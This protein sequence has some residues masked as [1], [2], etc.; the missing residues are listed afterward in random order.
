MFGVQLI[1]LNVVCFNIHSSFLACPALENFLATPYGEVNS[2]NHCD[3]GVSVTR[4]CSN[5]GVWG[6]ISYSGLCRCTQEPGWQDGLVGDVLTREC[7][8]GRVEVSCNEVGHWMTIQNDCACAADGIWEQSAIGVTLEKVCGNGGRMRRTCGANGFWEDIQDFNCECPKDGIWD[9]TPAGEF[10]RAGCS[11]GFIY[12]LCGENGEWTETYD[13]SSCY[14]SPQSGWQ[15]TLNGATATKACPYGEQV[16]ECDEWGRWGEIDSSNCMCKP[17]DGFEATPVNSYATTSCFDMNGVPD[18][19]HTQTRYCD[20]NGNWGDIDQTQCPI[21]WC[22]TVESWY[23]VPVGTRP[24]RVSIGCMSGE[25]WRVCNVNGQ[26]GPVNTDNCDC[27]YSLEDEIT[28]LL[29]PGDSYSLSCAIGERVYKCNEESGYFDPVDLS[30]CKC[31]S[32]GRFVSTPAGELASAACSVGTSVRL[33]SYDGQWEEADNSRCFCGGSDVWR[34]TNFNTTVS[35]LCDSG[36]RMRVCNEDGFWD[37]A[38]QD[39]CK[40]VSEGME[41]ALGSSAVIS[42][43]EGSIVYACNDGTFAAPDTSSCYCSSRSEFGI[44]WNRI[45]AGSDSPL[46]ICMNGFSQTRHCSDLTGHWEDLNSDE[47]HCTADGIW[48]ETGVGEYAYAPCEGHSTG[49]RRRMCYG[50]HWGDIDESTCYSEC[51]FDAGNGEITYVPVDSTLEVPCYVN[52]NGA[53]TY[54]CMHNEETNESY[55]QLIGSTCTRLFCESDLPPYIIHAG[56]SEERSCINGFTGTRTHTCQTDGTWSDYDNSNCSPIVCPATTYSGL[57]FPVTLADTYG[58]IECENGYHGTRKLFC[59]I[60]GEWTTDYLDECSINICPQEGEW[61]ETEAFKS[62]TISCP[63]DYTGSWTRQCLA[64]GEWEELAIPETCIPTP[65]TMKSIPYEGM[66]HVSRAPSVS[67]FTSLAIQEP[68]DGCDMKIVSV[69]NPEEEYTLRTNITKTALQG[70]YNNGGIFADFPLPPDADIHDLSHYLKYGEY[71]AIIPACWKALNGAAVPETQYEVTFHTTAIPPSSPT[72]ITIQYAATTFSVSFEEP[73]YVDEPYPVIAYYLS[74]QPPVYPE[75]RIDATKHTF[76]PFNYIAGSVS[77]LLRAENA[78]GLSS[79]DVEVP[80]NFDDVLIDA[81]ELL[82]MEIPSPEVVHLYSIPQ[83]SSVAITVGIRIPIAMQEFASYLNVFCNGEQVPGYEDIYQTKYTFIAS[84]DDV[85]T[86]SCYFTLAGSSSELTVL[87][88]PVVYSTTAYAAPEVTAIES[89]AHFIHLSWNEPAKYTNTPI[90]S[91]IVECKQQDA[92]TYSISY[93]ITALEADISVSSITVGPVVC[94]VGASS[95]YE[96][97][98]QTA[99]GMATIEELHTV[100]ANDLSLEVKQHGSYCEVMLMTSY[101]IE[102]IATINN[103]NYP[104]DSEV[105]LTCN[106]EHNQMTGILSMLDLS[107]TYSLTVSVPS[108]P[109][110][111][112]SEITTL[113]T[114]ENTFNITINEDLLYGTAAVAHIVSDSKTQVYCTAYTTPIDMDVF[115]YEYVQSVLNKDLYPISASKEFNYPFYNLKPSTTY[116]IA[117]VSSSN[118]QFVKENAFTTTREKSKIH[119]LDISRD[120]QSRDSYFLLSFNMPISVIT[121]NHLKL[122]CGGIPISLNMTF[123]DLT[124][125]LMIMSSMDTTIQPG[126]VC[127]IHFTALDSIMNVDHLY[128]YEAYYLSMTPF[129]NN[130]SYYEF[131]VTKDDMAPVLTQLTAPVLSDDSVLLFTASESLYLGVYPF[132]YTIDCM[133]LGEP[134]VHRVLQHDSIFKTKHNAVKGYVDVSFTTGLLPNLHTCT[135]SFVDEVYYINYNKAICPGEDGKCVFTFV[136]R[137]SN[138]DIMN[139]HMLSITPENNAVNVDISAPVVFTF[140]RDVEAVKSITFRCLEC[141]TVEFTLPAECEAATCII[142]N[143]TNWEAK[144]T[145]AIYLD[146]DAFKS[147]W[148]GYAVDN[149]SGYST[150][151]TGASMCNMDFIA[152]DWNSDCVCKN[153]STHC[154]CT[155]GATA[156]LKAF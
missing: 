152:E 120:D 115:T 61:P 2:D 146:A 111:L 126:S 110:E 140:N 134:T 36:F 23:A 81:A 24:T 131:T 142:R 47:C 92:S 93:A 76:G 149:M 112:K 108:I 28:R 145:Y 18:E 133:K 119:V 150:F 50:S 71:K 80:Y 12:R 135:L 128:G 8:Y 38:I 82:N 125:Y 53:D 63:A 15:L 104:F 5:E 39:S 73:T 65:P 86:A 100:S 68:Y 122:S 101:C 124:E 78:Y 141:E 79:P 138:P 106:E 62:A 143:P 113:A 16:R 132:T 32:D 31:A 144:R 6:T 60:T 40:C 58:E 55:M 151:T 98:E 25:R 64:S 44:I 148:D 136:S 130:S 21:K 59:S 155:C 91:Y 77:L 34:E 3:N 97:T 66:K 129:F 85:A 11:S 54:K 10:A 30:T 107:H 35:V 57:S 1:L 137:V 7:S 37:P 103:D 52:F 96:A 84:G 43:D 29:R 19:E 75:V 105:A 72:H 116:S 88:I 83:E 33:C 114:D 90:K 74:F 48:G 41:A 51:E 117:C 13:R 147:K 42:C 14:C 153:T 121:A 69:E 27:T 9:A 70:R 156:I 49:L 20:A 95:S 94:R 118:V 46:L 87:S 45:P 102:A 56:E 99:W 17:Q 22:P 89:E 123:Y 4:T 127:N 154:Q 67:L 109:V 26:W 139:L